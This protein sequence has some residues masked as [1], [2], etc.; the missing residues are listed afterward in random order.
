MVPGLKGNVMRRSIGH[1]LSGAAKVLATVALI[2]APRAGLA[3]DI[4]WSE[5]AYNPQPRDGDLILPLPCGGAMTFRA[6]GVP[7]DGWMADRQIL[8]GN[9]NDAVAYAESQRYATLAGAFTDPDDAGLRVYWLAAY[10]LT[11][12]QRAAIE[13][14]CLDDGVPNRRPAAGMTW[15]DAIS[16]ADSYT[17]WLLETAPD[18]LPQED[19]ISGFVRLPTEAEWEFAARGGLAVPEA[20]FRDRL[21]PM[22]GV[23]AQN[24]WFQGSRSANGDRRP[25]GLLDANPLGL[26][27]V[28]GNVEELV[29]EP[30]RLNRLGR[31]HG[32]A[33]GATVRGGSYLT[34]ETAI[35]TAMR[36]ELPPYYGTDR[37]ELA[38]VGVRFAIGAQVVTSPQRLDA[39]RTAMAELAAGSDRFADPGT[40]PV[41]E[42]DGDDTSG[43]V[44]DAPGLAVGTDDA[45][46]TDGG[47]E[48]DQ[49]ATFDLAALSLA[50][51]DPLTALADAASDADD[52]E[53]ATRLEAI[54][55]ALRA[56]Q[57]M[58]TANAGRTAR[59][60]IRLGADVGSRLHAEAQSLQMLR[61]NLQSLAA[62]AAA[63][64]YADRLGVHLD[65]TERSLRNNLDLYVESVIVGAEV[66]DQL[67]MTG[68]LSILA[69]E[70]EGRDDDELIPFACS[71]VG[72]VAAYR[73]EG[74]V[75][76]GVWLED[77]LA[78]PV[79]QTDGTCWRENP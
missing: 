62:V 29:L 72:H 10:E 44:P 47:D 17:V 34:P 48:P 53:V 39:I 40:V 51:D 15:V 75:A 60:L 5:P 71:F 52:P 16:L 14:T 18:A 25:I 2:A 45:G 19:G 20:E 31:L 70:L 24:V 59:S 78:A 64:R 38:T 27:D 63:R 57:E 76:R 55:V 30:F 54:S 12:A 21:P 56:E 77:L 74:V 42:P 67:L 66:Y 69:N 33:G 73:G 8:L 22:E 35:R 26:H 32:Q 61:G 23:L 79:E 65:N 50:V 58:L 28:L 43:T 37:N 3:Q 4:T 46:P 6:V 36:R 9:R 1:L 13:G 49:V 7:Q 68:Q 41:A 11:I